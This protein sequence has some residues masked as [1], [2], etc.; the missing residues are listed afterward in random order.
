MKRKISIIGGAGN[1]GL[2]IAEILSISKNICNEIVIVDINENVCEGRAIDISQANVSINYQKIIGTSNFENISNSDVII[3]AAGIARKP[4]MTRADLISTNLGVIQSVSENIKKYSPNSF[5]IVITNP[6]DIMVYS[7]Y[8]FIGCK[9]NMI[10][11]MAG[12]LDGRRFSYQISQHLGIGGEKINSMVIG[13]HNDSMV[14]LPRYSSISGIPLNDFVKNGMISKEKLDELITKTKHGGVEIVKLLMNGSATFNPAVCA[15][16]MASAYLNDE[17]KIMSCS[18]LL[19][20][21][22]SCK[23]IFAGTPVVISSNGVERVIELALNEEE[24]NEMQ[25]SLQTIKDEI[26]NLNN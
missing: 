12:E 3:I 23:E 16:S 10:L 13:A 9:S 22:Y 18:T 2:N 11:G 6:L 17:K 8:K 25:K 19:N 1:I 4:S 7:A 26:K 5:I 15:V 24:M 21:E 14:V 20:G